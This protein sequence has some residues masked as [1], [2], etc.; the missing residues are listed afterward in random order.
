MQSLRVLVSK[1]KFWSATEEDE[2][3]ETVTEAAK[4]LVPGTTKR[5]AK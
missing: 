1:G 3:F 5:G 4:K 2:L